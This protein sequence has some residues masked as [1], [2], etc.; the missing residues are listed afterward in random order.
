MAMRND[1]PLASLLARAGQAL[2]ELAEP[3]W[4]RIASND[5]GRPQDPSLKTPPNDKTPPEQGV[6]LVRR[7]GFEPRTR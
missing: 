3:G 6:C 5:R 1:D 7:Q 2:R 4:D